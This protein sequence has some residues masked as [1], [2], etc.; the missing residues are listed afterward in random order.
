LFLGVPILEFPNHA[1]ARAHHEVAKLLLALKALGNL[2]LVNGSTDAAFHE[3]L[4]DFLRIGVARRPGTIDL[5][6]RGSGRKQGIESE[7]RRDRGTPNPSVQK[8]IHEQEKLVNVQWEQLNNRSSWPL[9]HSTRQ[10]LLGSR[11]KSLKGL[12]R[13]QNA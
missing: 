10:Q 6:D 12:F 11:R 5:R 13:H 8:S 4:N 1:G 2:S 7:E 3:G 9:L